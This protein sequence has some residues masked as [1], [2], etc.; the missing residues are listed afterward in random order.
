VGVLYSGSNMSM[1]DQV[2]AAI[3]QELQRQAEDAGGLEVRAVEPGTLVVSGVI[4]LEA[5]AAAVVGAVAGGP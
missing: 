4:D 1:E 3:A 5:V 2:Q